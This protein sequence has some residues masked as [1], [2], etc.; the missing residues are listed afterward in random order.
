MRVQ[1]SCSRLL[2]Q[3]YS[4]ATLEEF[5]VSRSTIMSK[6]LRGSYVYEN[7]EASRFVRSG[8]AVSIVGRVHEHALAAEH[9]VLTD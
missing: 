3:Q 2:P 8:K 5:T 4:C 7:I 6:T 1:V 9:N